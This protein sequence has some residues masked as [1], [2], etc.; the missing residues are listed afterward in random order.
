MGEG[1]GWSVGLEVG[2]GDT[3]CLLNTQS[4]LLAGGPARRLTSRLGWA[5]AG[6]DPSVVGGSWECSGECLG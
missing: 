3:E 6:T 5:T 2:G 1:A 4:V